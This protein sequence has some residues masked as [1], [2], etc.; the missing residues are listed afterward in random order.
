MSVR[1]RPPRGTS[2]GDRLARPVRRDVRRAARSPSTT[3]ERGATAGPSPDRL[4]LGGTVSG[5]RGRPRAS[6]A[7]RFGRTSGEQLW[8][9][10]TATATLDLVLSRATCARPGTRDRHPTDGAGAT[11]AAGKFT[12]RCGGPLLRLSRG[13]R[14]RGAWRCSTFDGER[15]ARPARR[16]VL[17]PR[18]GRAGTRPLLPWQRRRL[19]VLRTPRGAAGPAGEGHRLR[20]GRPAISN[21]RRFPPD[22]FL[23]GRTAATGCSS[24][25]AGGPLPGRGRRRLRRLRM[26]VPPGYRRR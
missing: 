16:R 21:R 4:L 8:P 18:G 23:A 17:L 2:N 14:P 15:A 11:T 9:T 20:R 19:Q 26:A 25:T 5:F 24:T 1:T 3:S 12:E 7:N 13:P 22:V 10:S 6:Q